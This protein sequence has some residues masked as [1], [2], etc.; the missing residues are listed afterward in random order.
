MRYRK[1][2]NGEIYQPRGLVLITTLVCLGVIVAMLLIAMQ[3]SLKQKRR[4]DRELQMEQTRWL[5]IAATE[6]AEGLL[7]GKEKVTLRL[8]FDRY[9]NAE[10]L[11]T[12]ASTGESS[13]TEIDVW[14]GLKDRPE[15][16]TRKITRTV[17][18]NTGST[19]AP[20]KQL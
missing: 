12:K 20:E 2:R 18:S 7:E 3:T 19:E 10:A 6:Q 14:I 5:A 1:R 9:A 16:Q 8:T 11:I 17:F 13:N 15:L 4:L